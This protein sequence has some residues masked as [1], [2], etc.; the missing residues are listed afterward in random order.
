MTEKLLPLWIEVRK[1]LLSN[2]IAGDKDTLRSLISTCDTF[3]YYNQGNVTLLPIDIWFDAMREVQAALDSTRHY[4]CDIV[5]TFVVELALFT[6]N[7]TF[8]TFSE[9]MCKLIDEKDTSNLMT[10]TNAIYHLGMF[11]S[12]FRRRFREILERKDEN[13]NRLIRMADDLKTSLIKIISYTEA[14]SVSQR[15]CSILEH[16]RMN[17]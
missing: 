17:S 15:I 10:I 8:A 5:K 13:L 2:Y 11:N 12:V 9:L 6:E 7:D 16:M 3:F 14:V 4:T 1:V